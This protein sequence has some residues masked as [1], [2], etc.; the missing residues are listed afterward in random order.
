MNDE[1]GTARG[2]PHRDPDVQAAGEAW[3]DVMIAAETA[4]HLAEEVGDHA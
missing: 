1:Y 4:A 3:I 2:D